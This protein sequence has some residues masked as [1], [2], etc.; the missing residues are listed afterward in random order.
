M[1]RPGTMGSNQPP[2]SIGAMCW[3]QPIKPIQPGLAV[4]IVSGQAGL[5]Q[6]IL[7]YWG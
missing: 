5:G 1:A 7:E 3:D 4:P 6:G 2:K